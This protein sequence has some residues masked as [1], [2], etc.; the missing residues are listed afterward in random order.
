ML[1]ESIEEMKNDQLT[2]DHK[3][4]KI[5][6][7]TRVG[8]EGKYSCDLTLNR[9]GFSLKGEGKVMTISTFWG[10]VDCSEEKKYQN[11]HSLCVFL[12]KLMVKLKEV[13]VVH[14]KHQL[15]AD[16][17]PMRALSKLVSLN[18]FQNDLVEKWVSFE[19]N[20]MDAH[21][22]SNVKDIFEC[23]LGKMKNLK[24]IS[25]PFKR[26]CCRYDG[27]AVWRNTDLE[28]LSNIELQNTIALDHLELI[29]DGERL[30]NKWLKKMCEHKS[31]LFNKIQVRQELKLT[32]RGVENPRE[33]IAQIF[34][35]PIA[36]KCKV[37]NLKVG[38]YLFFNE[39][40][41]EVWKLFS[42]IKI[43]S[44]ITDRSLQISANTKNN[45]S[46]LMAKRICRALQ[47]PENISLTFRTKNESKS[48]TEQ[49]LMKYNI[50]GIRDFMLNF[51]GR[52][53]ITH[54]EEDFNVNNFKG[55]KKIYANSDY[56]QEEGV[57]P[58][59]N[60][61][62]RQTNIQ[63]EPFFVIETQDIIIQ[64]DCKF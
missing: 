48:Y 30:Q 60:I 33:T 42:C 51:H 41:E 28:G 16:C 62:R 24:R 49:G 35:L 2:R 64:T 15:Y 26:Y 18:C 6:H 9:L 38:L 4:D 31:S 14:F 59:L 52:N 56:G 11:W 19:G 44:F 34:N 27:E 54:F 50:W 43:S 55:Y 46:L 13:L 1:L 63:E 17:V 23:M 20:D 40:I 5:K 22:F 58:S 12:D 8:H 53:Q 29:I 10:Y 25:M 47:L 37:V 7:N 45:S 57:F 32:I 39:E 61:A 21:P 3:V 36:S